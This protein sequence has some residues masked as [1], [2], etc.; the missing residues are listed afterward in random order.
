[1]SAAAGRIDTDRKDSTEVV[2]RISRLVDVAR[3]ERQSHDE[4]DTGQ[5]QGEQEDGSPPEL[6]EERA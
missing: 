6:L 1:M 5:G 2:D 4:C 3:H